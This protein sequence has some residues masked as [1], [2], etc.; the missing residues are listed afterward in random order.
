MGKPSPCIAG[1]LFYQPSCRNDVLAINSDS[2]RVAGE[3]RGWAK[4]LFLAEV[5]F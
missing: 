4:G 3:G 5:L 1:V 2:K